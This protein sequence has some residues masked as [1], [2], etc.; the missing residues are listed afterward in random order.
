MLE[1][2]AGGGSLSSLVAVFISSS[3]FYNRQSAFNNILIMILIF[4]PEIQPR[5][6]RS[7]SEWRT[8]IGPLGAQPPGEAL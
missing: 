4:Y 5:G 6:Q 1:N 2:D 7:I 8:C 3:P